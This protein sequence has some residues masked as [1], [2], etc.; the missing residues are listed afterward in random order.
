MA[1][2]VAMFSVASVVGGGS[3]IASEARGVALSRGLVA[4]GLVSRVETKFSLWDFHWRERVTAT[5]YAF[6]VHGFAC[7]VC[8]LEAC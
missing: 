2:C 6:V 8:C 7:L 3:A 1:E 5:C 4:R